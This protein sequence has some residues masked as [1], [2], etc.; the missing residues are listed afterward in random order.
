VR[1]DYTNAGAPHSVVLERAANAVH[2]T[3]G[4]RSVSATIL[5]EDEGCVVLEIEG[6][7]RVVH[8]ARREGVVDALLGGVRYR[9]EK[10]ERGSAPRRG[11]SAGAAS[12]GK[13]TTPMPGK[14]VSV[15]VRA[16]E[17]VAAGHALLV[18]ESMKMQNDVLAPVAGT[19]AAVRCA[20]GAS[21]EYG[22]L[23]VEITPDSAPAASPEP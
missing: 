1:Y 13:V 10:P 23:L 7:V 17:R 11:G 19:V 15:H 6:R 2:A 22:D 20:E 18:L 5:H 16:G 14:V 4:G 8:M 3:I 9:L 12:D 21:V